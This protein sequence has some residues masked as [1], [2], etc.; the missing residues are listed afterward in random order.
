[1]QLVGLHLDA[2]LEQEVCAD[3][4]DGDGDGLLCQVATTHL[5]GRKLREEDGEQNPDYHHEDGL[6]GVHE[7]YERN[8]RHERGERH[9]HIASHEQPFIERVQADN[10]PGVSTELAQEASTILWH[11]A[12]D[13]ETDP[14]AR[15]ARRCPGVCCCCR[16]ARSPGRRT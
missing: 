9:D 8:R 7:K 15:P 12:E 10:L 2:A 11:E 3:A 16:L 14:C 5:L 1:M 13:T 6:V 4:G